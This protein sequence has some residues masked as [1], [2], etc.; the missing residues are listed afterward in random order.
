MT[1]V[2]VQI[3]PASLTGSELREAVVAA[4][5]GIIERVASESNPNQ[6]RRI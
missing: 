2:L 5:L 6:D 4:G 1:K 3:A